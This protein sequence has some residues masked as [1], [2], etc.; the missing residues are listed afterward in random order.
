[1]TV[2]AAFGDPVKFIMVLPMRKSKSRPVSVAW[3]ERTP[4]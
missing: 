4:G 3:A 1:L 2:I